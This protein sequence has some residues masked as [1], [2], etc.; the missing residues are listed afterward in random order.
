MR[1][2]WPLL[3]ACVAA[4]AIAGGGPAAAVAPCT[5]PQLTATFSVIPNSAGAGNIVYALRLTNRSQRTCFVSG[6]AGLG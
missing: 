1:A 5:S 3:G 6:L 2:R 4:L